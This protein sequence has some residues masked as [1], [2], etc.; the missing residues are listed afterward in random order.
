MWMLMHP[1]K[2]Q[3][4][5][6]ADFGMSESWLSTLI[7]SDM[8]QSQI[9]HL[10]QTYHSTAMIGLRSRAEGAAT[11]AL[12]RLIE[13]LE[14]SEEHQLT[15]SF[16]LEAATKLL[17]KMSNGEDAK[18]ISPG[19]QVN[20]NVAEEIKQAMLHLGEAK[21]ATPEENTSQDDDDYPRIVNA[22]EA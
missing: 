8:F 1:D 11:M 2:S 5:I 4:E 13:V 21:K 12:N 7:S 14:N 15:P 19:V 16:Y 18:S 10:R 6:A 20:V 22:E 3:R 17:E 9:E